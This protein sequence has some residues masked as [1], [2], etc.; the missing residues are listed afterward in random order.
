MKL[1]QRL[2]LWTVL[3]AVILFCGYTCNQGAAPEEL[4]DPCDTVIV[5]IDT[6][7]NVTDTQYVNPGDTLG[8]DTLFHND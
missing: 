1:L 4:K 5:H 2:K 7:I 6:T 8:T 3:V